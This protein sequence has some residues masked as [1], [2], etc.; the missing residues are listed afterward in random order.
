MTQDAGTMP[1]AQAAANGKGERV[2]LLLAQLDSLPTLPAVA[3]RLLEL[4]TAGNSS[5]REVVRLI[6]SDQSLTARILAMARKTP[7]TVGTPVT[8]VDKAVL[9]LGFE[10]VRNTVLSIKVFEV[11]ARRDEQPPTEFDRAEFW[12]HSLAVACAAQLTAERARLHVEPDLAF[13]CGLLHDIGKVALDACLPKSYDRVIRRTNAVRGSIADVER[14]FLGVD[15]TIVGR[16]LAQKWRFPPSLLECIWLH[17]LGPAGLPASVEHANLVRL[18][19]FAD[20]LARE[21]RLGYSGN[22]HPD[23]A[24][25]RLAEQIGLSRTQYDEIVGLLAPCIEERAHLI[26]LDQLTSH[27]L[28][29]KALSDANEELSRANAALAASNQQLTVRSR[30]FAALHAM[31]RRMTAGLTV[32]DVCGAA[33]EAIQKALEA[34]AVAVFFYSRSTGLL[35]LGIADGRPDNPVRSI[36]LDGSSVSAPD[37]WA[38][39]AGS[40]AGVVFLPSS[41]AAPALTEYVQT[42]ADAPLPWFCPILQNGRCTA[43]AFLAGQAAS[44]THWTSESAEFGAILTALRLWLHNVESHHHAQRLNEDL[45]EINRRLQQAQQE[46]ARARSLAMVAEMAAGAAHELNNP[47]AVISGRAQMLKSAP[48]DEATGKVADVIAEQ[49]GRCSQIVSELMDFAKPAEPQKKPVGV[50]RL[51]EHIRDTWLDRT[52]LLPDQL[53]LELSDE[54]P[55]IDVDPAQVEAAFD[56]L[57]RNATEAM[58]G[59]AP[60]IVVNCQWD[61]T[62]ERVVIR[63]DDNGRGMGPETLERAMDPFYSHRPAGRGRGLG[64]S[65]AARWIEINGG[66]LRLDSR[67]GEGT[68]AFVEF[69]ASSSTASQ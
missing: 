30:H 2:E 18:V 63:V 64:L 40:G 35:H 28:Y 23:I 15:H 12:K 58:E 42:R 4:T 68:T 50:G 67:A 29:I 27:D 51:L 31:N 33:A 36:G 45:S 48:P 54:L 32:G 65:R 5:A 16:R 49:A 25:S 47:L 59:R 37:G 60:R 21:L 22:F 20:R 19:H 39:D 56:E 14:E 7:L 66:R 69:A 3:T 61:P 8:T 46:A 52:S 24:A 1:P 41:V 26:G 6:E 11:F 43:G 34:P 17:Q 44:A 13:V 57:I 55:A 62:D 10:S 9:L 38:T 53:V